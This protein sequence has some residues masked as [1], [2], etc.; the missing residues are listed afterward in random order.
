MQEGFLSALSQVGGPLEARPSNIQRRMAAGFPDIT[1][2]VRRALL[3]P[4]LS[5]VAVCL[6]LASTGKAASSSCSGC[7]RQRG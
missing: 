7:M 2:R 5:L 4:P 6:S 3:P 1:A